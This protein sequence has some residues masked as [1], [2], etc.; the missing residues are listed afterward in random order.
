MAQRAKT[1]FEGVRRAFLVGLILPGQPGYVV[2]EHLDELAD[3]AKS[4]GVPIA[5]RALQKRSRP[6]SA[7]FIGRGKVDEVRQM[8]V[9][10]DAEMVVFDND[11]SPAQGKN[12]EDALEVRVIDRSELILDIFARRARSREAKLQ[13]EL[14]QLQYLLPRLRR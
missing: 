5:G 2:E 14:A 11:L 3:L 12:L 4:A 7:T 13:V 8:V 9:A 1:T 6:D 10:T